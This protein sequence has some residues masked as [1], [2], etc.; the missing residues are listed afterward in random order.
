MMKEPRNSLSDTLKNLMSSGYRLADDQI[1]ESLKSDD[2]RLDSVEQIRQEQG[3][4][5]VIAVSSVQRCMKL[6]FVEVL[7]PQTDFSLMTL[8]R[9]LFPMRQG[10]GVSLAPVYLR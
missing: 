5:L 1:D 6:I 2:W 10:T 8:L 7:L 3:K 9:R 4:T